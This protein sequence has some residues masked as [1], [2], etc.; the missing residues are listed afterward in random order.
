ME[1]RRSKDDWLNAARLA[2]LRGGIGAVRVETLA[3]QL[4]V[5]KGSFYW[6]FA[7]RSALTDALL[8]EWEEEADLLIGA[9]SAGGREG[10]NGLL[11]QISVNVMASERGEVPSDAA[12]FAWA[13]VDPSIRDRVDAAEEERVALLATLLGNRE[14]AELAY[15]AYLGFILR[16][17]HGPDPERGFRLVRELFLLLPGAERGADKNVEPGIRGAG[18]AHEGRNT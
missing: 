8:S 3:Q 14:K 9:I 10:L 6:H 4:G 5:T 13:T 11:E 16:R 15:M 7:N 12:I 1:S 2:L 18:T 17:R